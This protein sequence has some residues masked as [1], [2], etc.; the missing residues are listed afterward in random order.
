MEFYSE[1]WAEWAKQHPVLAFAIG[2]VLLI[3]LIVAVV[4]IYRLQGHGRIRRW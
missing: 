2:I 4:G 1:A 3:V